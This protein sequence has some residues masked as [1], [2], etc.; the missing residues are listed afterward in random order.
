MGDFKIPTGFLLSVWMYSPPILITIGTLGNCITLIVLTN[1]KCKKSSFT[2]YL[3]A[4]AIV[5]T[6]ILY[7]FPL[8]TWLKY[9]F[10]FAY[11]TY[12]IILC[13][14]LAFTS[15]LLPQISSWMIV[16]LTM[17]RALCT[18]SPIKYKNLCRPKRGLTVVGAI[19]SL[20][21]AFDSHMLYG[22]SLT[23]TENFTVCTFVDETYAK[24]YFNAFVWMDFSAYF[25]LPFVLIVCANSATAFM[26][27]RS[28]KSVTSTGSQA[29]ISRDRYVIV[30][31]LLVSFAFILLVSPF[32]IFFALKPFLFGDVEA[33]YSSSQTELIVEMVVYNLV[34]L[35]SAINFFLYVL[36]G[37]RFRSDLKAAFCNIQFNATT[38]KPIAVTGVPIKRPEESPNQGESLETID[39]SGIIQ[40]VRDILVCMFV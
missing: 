1:R 20:L 15:Y 32:S 38:A 14:G 30:I 27:Y 4:L 7:N 2:V 33:F 26:V 29:R 39:K 35:N 19:I 37:E 23:K 24:F 13:K 8:N 22:M 3:T 31:T 34:F 5:D 17:E 12:N 40:K 10:N 28:S 11:E 6:L 18:Y 16:V 9:V 36:S 25:L 21:A